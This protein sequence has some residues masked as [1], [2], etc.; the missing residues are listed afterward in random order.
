M[1]VKGGSPAD[2]A[3]ILGDD[4]IVQF[5]GVSI[6]NIYDYVYAL[7]DSKPGIPTSLV[8]LR[9]YKL[10]SLI[11]VPEPRSQESN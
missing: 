5:N 7:G 3:G 4:T 9:N 11:I 6:K 1:G 10:L 2:K 8:V